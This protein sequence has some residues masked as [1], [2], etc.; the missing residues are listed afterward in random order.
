MRFIGLLLLIILSALF[1]GEPLVTS[2]QVDSYVIKGYEFSVKGKTKDFALRSVIVPSGGDPIFL[3]EEAMVEALAAK[4]Q[5]LVN[6]RIFTEV[7][8]TYALDSY[9]RGTAYYIATFYVEDA[10]TFLT[11][12]YPKFDN[13]TVGLRLGVK[14]YDKN[15]FGTFSDLYIS[16]TVSQGNG[17]RTGW[18]NREDALDVQISSLPIGKSFLDI[19]FDYDR[20]KGSLDAGTFNFAFDW[21]NL[22][23][24]GSKLSIAPWGKFKPASDFSSWN[25]DEYGVAWRLGPFKQNESTF[26]LYNQV[27]RYA[28]LK[29]LYTLT[30]LDQHGL[31]FFS[32]P[33]RFRIST[34]S[35]AVVG[36]GA[37]SSM[38]VGATLG[39]DFS[40]PFGF[41]WSSSV[42]A[43]LHYSYNLTDIPVPYSY[44][45]SN[46]LSKSNINWQ[47]NFR[48]GIRFSL[49]YITDLYPQDEYW[50]SKSTWYVAT[51][52]SWFPLATKYVNPSVQLRGF[53][54]DEKK[55]A[56]F[57][58]I[59]IAD[60]MRGYLT[61]TVESMVLG[62]AR[63]YGAVINLNLTSKFI[64]FGFAKS[65]ASPFIDIGIFHD[66]TNPDKPI[67]ISSA[68]LDGWAILNKFPSYPIRGSL[69]F[70]LQDVRKAI[71]KEKDFTEI[72]WELY[73]G[74]GLF[75]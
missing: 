36:S 14:M 43:I 15:L 21:N 66:E 2:D 25:P 53:V 58:N 72:E 23:I 1:A 60:S 4:K 35:D 29:R 73:I 50:E 33:I 11:I 69:G 8:F 27:K 39:T 75:F 28:D 59:T 62:L 68:G 55:R 7:D 65:Y 57:S 41:T 45:L 38:N 74:M 13:D 20:T 44:L 63:E 16:G 10:S 22:V 12:P 30:Y 18:D 51:T 6:K 64:N 49:D 70:N 52:L 24:K 5:L 46:T 34:E 56:Y 71:D 26:S 19:S 9:S 54:A 42:G 40:L 32:H 61:N 37:L 47:G 3:S 48:K 17:G 31:T 67:I